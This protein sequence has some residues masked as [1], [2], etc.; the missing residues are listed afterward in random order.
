[1]RALRTVL[2]ALA[3]C[4]LAPAA[5]ASAWS[6]SYHNPLRN[7]KTGGPLSC[8]YPSVTYAPTPTVSYILVCTSGFNSDAFPI[9]RS[10]D[11][12]H[13]QPDGFVFPPGHQPWWAVNS[14][15]RPTGGR[16]WAPEINR[17]AGRWV[18][19]FAA[20]DNAAKL[21]LRIPGHGRVTN[22]RMVVGY[23]TSTSLAGP[24][25]TGVLHYAGQ[26]N[27]VSGVREDLVP[28][29][30][31]SLLTDP[32]T[33]QLYLYW[34]DQPHQI[35]AG[36]LSPSG[37]TLEPQIKEVL[38]VS[39]PFECDPRDHHCTIEAPE[40]FFAFGSF[41]LLYSGASTWDSS[42]AVGAAAAPSP[43]GPFAKLGHPILRQ[44]GG[45]YST[46]HT[47]EPVLGPDGNS[48]IL[49]HARTSPGVHRPSDT[50]YL[51]LGRFG[52]TDGWPTIR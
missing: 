26:F 16:Y 31:P 30:D 44:G 22:G 52:W 15:G 2:L 18:V 47:S 32:S 21:G 20:E 50:R 4:V 14:T 43:L 13:W 42:Y 27:G 34:S 35:W 46:G 12:V 41:Y 1:L 8:P 19:Y 39:E 28:S 36:E 7:P 6:L 40:P 3:I 29:I 48:Y 49:Y 5:V 10:T 38:S 9:Y 23:A 25:Q 17:I 11:L 24:W 37:T 33:G 51:M 45:F